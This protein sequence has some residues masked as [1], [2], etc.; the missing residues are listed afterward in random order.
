MTRKNKEAGDRLAKD[1]EQSEQQEEAEAAKEGDEIAED[2]H[3][4]RRILLSQIRKVYTD[5]LAS[6]PK[7]YSYDEWAYFL[8]LLGEDEADERFHRNART[9]PKS[10]RKGDNTSEHEKPIDKEAREFASAGQ[11]LARDAD[12]EGDATVDGEQITQWSWI[13]HRSP[14]MGDR[15]EPEWLLDRMFRRLEDSLHET[16]EQQKQDRDDNPE[17]PNEQGPPSDQETIHD[18]YQDTRERQG[19]DAG[20][21]G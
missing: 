15:D 20:P 14:L 16:E 4:Y 12:H 1:F 9:R 2:E 18:Q 8:K 6:Q 21:A 3:H 5:S 17:V 10:H 11:K 19:A 13:G 7:H